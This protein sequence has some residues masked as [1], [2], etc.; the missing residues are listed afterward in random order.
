MAVAVSCANHDM[1]AVPEPA[2]PD[3]AI[4]DAT[5]T[6]CQASSDEGWISSRSVLFGIPFDVCNGARTASQANRARGWV[7][8]WVLGG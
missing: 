8:G 6:R 5:R 4:A 1:T 2:I 7:G 3:D